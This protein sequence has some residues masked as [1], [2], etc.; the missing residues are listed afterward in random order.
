[1]AGAFTHMCIVNEAISSFS[2]T[3]QIGKILRE[4]KSF[5]TLGSVSPDIPYLS[6]LANPEL[7]NWADLMH[8]SNTNGIVNNGMHSLHA[9]QVKA[10]VWESQLAWLLGFVAHLVADATIHPIVESLVGPYTDPGVRTNHRECEMIQDVMIFKEVMNL[11]VTATEFTDL[12]RSSVNSSPFNKVIEFWS[13][14]AEVNYPLAGKFPAASVISSYINE[15]DTAE[16]G[17]TLARLFRHMGADFVYRSYDELTKTSKDLVTKYY[18]DIQLPNRLKGSFIEDGF[19]YTVKNLV[20]AWSKI[21]R[22]LFTNDNVIQF[23]PNWNLD[24]GVDQETG[25]RTYWS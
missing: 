7:S 25:I 9:T 14:H 17:N 1:M 19:K 21:E 12:L 13:N 3:L 11:E 22:A 5:L 10:D 8:Y 4:Y 15:L 18:S 23:I 16:G 6:Q 20:N 2:P 24:T